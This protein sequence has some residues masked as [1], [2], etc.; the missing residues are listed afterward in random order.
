[1]KSSY[2][3]RKS[4]SA[5]IAKTPEVIAAEM[6]ACQWDSVRKAYAKAFFIK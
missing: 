3:L 1:M 6:A 2:V 4:S 5:A